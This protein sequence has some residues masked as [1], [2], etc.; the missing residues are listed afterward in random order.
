M[1]GTRVLISMDDRFLEKVDVVAKEESRSRSELIREAIRQYLL[2]RL[3]NTSRELTREG[4]S[5][6]KDSG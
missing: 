5:W 1:A 4:E 3:G 2:S 6:E